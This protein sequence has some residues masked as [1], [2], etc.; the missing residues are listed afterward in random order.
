MATRKSVSLVTSTKT[1]PKSTNIRTITIRHRN[2]KINFKCFKMQFQIKGRNSLNTHPLKRA[3]TTARPSSPRSKSLRSNPKDRTTCTIQLSKMPRKL[4]LIRKRTTTKRICTSKDA[5]QAMIITTMTIT[6]RT[7]CHQI[8]RDKLKNSHCN[9]NH[10][11]VNQTTKSQKLTCHLHTH[12][13]RWWGTSKIFQSHRSRRWQAT[14]PIPKTMVLT[15]TSIHF[16]L[17]ST[18]MLRKKKKLKSMFA[19]LPLVKEWCTQ[20]GG[21]D[22]K[23][24]RKSTNCFTVTMQNK[25]VVKLIMILSP[26]LTLMGH[27]CRRWFK[28]QI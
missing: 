12:I 19:T 4:C 21:L 27:F 14:R 23:H 20:T 24:I 6:D 2:N 11:R 17:S 18:K 9:Q 25:K 16:S 28:T 8:N 13:P 1:R 3:T 10:I 5:A 15:K 7:Q 26:V 22:L